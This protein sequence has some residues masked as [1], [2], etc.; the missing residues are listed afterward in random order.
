MRQ[1][2]RRATCAVKRRIIPRICVKPVM[3]ASGGGLFV[4][5]QTIDPIMA[6]TFERRPGDALS[7]I[8]IQSTGVIYARFVGRLSIG[9]PLFPMLCLQK[10]FAA[11]RPAKKII[12]TLGDPGK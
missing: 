5:V 9:S 2:K 7:T 6:F 8:V 12:L 11:L 4:P 3:R 1:K 10:S